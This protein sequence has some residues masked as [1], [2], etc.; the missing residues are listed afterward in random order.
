VAESFTSTCD[1][2]GLTKY[3]FESRGDPGLSLENKNE[4]SNESYRP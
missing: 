1:I 4:D 3:G 2:T